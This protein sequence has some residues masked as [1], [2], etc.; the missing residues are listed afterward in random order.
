MS[1]KIVINTRYPGYFGLSAA[2]WV[3][4]KAQG[5]TEGL[6]CEIDRDCPILIGI[7]TEWGVRANSSCSQLE[8]FTL[9]GD[10][11]RIVSDRGY[12]EVEEPHAAYWDTAR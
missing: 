8:V 7:V 9:K 2:A 5:G 1:K 6:Q 10:R 12:E 11:Y 3:E 4:Y